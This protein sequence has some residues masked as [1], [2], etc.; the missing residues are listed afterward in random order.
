[1]ADH[2]LAHPALL[3]IPAGLQARTDGAIRHGLLS[4]HGEEQKPA[5]ARLNALVEAHLRSAEIE[6]AG[7]APPD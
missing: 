5:W 4:H 2:Y 3:P 1:M 7:Q 6:I